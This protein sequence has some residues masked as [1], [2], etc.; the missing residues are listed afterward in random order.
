[1]E[2][3]APDG[4]LPDAAID[5]MALRG[6]RTTDGRRV[7]LVAAIAHVSGIVLGQRQ[8]PDE[9]DESSAVPELLAPLDEAGMVLTLDALH[10]TKK[11]AR[12]IT[13]TPH[14]QYVLI[15]KGDQPLA[16]ETARLLYRAPIPSSPGA[17]P[18]RTAAVTPGSSTARSA[19][20]SVS[21]RSPR[22]AVVR[23]AKTGGLSPWI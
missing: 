7:F 11:T 12:L 8:V 6:A 15:L 19:P 13:E 10:T 1:M 14:A 3:P 17:P 21:W 20:A 9:R 4:S 2:H 23:S 16:H 22:A 18:P 5:G